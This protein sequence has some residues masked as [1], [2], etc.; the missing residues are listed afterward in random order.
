[1]AG[2]YS[3]KVSVGTTSDPNSYLYSGNNVSGYSED[4]MY[5]LSLEDMV[6]DFKRIKENL[7]LARQYEG[8]M[9]RDEAILARNSETQA[10]D[11][12]NQRAQ[13]KKIMDANNKVLNGQQI[14]QN[15]K[16]AAIQAQRRASLGRLDLLGG[17]K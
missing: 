16:Q 9:N 15:D 12:E 7:D 8:I 6:K 1:M 5:N 10:L 14:A 17:D 2:E 3:S 4:P 11:L 13:I